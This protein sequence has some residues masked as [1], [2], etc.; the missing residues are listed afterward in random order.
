MVVVTA[1]TGYVSGMEFTSDGL[2]IV[3]TGTDNRLRLWDVFTGANMLVN[4]SHQ[5]YLQS[6]LHVIL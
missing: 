6:H 3:S 2:F 4:Y 5:V 1:H